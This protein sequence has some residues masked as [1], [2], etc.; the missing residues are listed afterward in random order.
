MRRR[1]RGRDVKG[2]AGWKVFCRV[3]VGC[4]VTI[5]VPLGS[6]T[7]KGK[8]PNCGLDR[9]E[10]KEE[11]YSDNLEEVKMRSLFQ[12]VCMYCIYTPSNP[13]P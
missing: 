1:G 5:K 11:D 2:R 12:Y 9:R 13:I 3:P 10:E 4:L 8:F 6:F 7:S